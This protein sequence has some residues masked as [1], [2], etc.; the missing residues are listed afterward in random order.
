[1]LSALLGWWNGVELWLTQ[2]PF[3]MQFTLVMAVALPVSAGIA[4]LIDRAVDRVPVL[5]REVAA[6]FGA[7]RGAGPDA[8]PGS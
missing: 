4:W 8:D 3:A 5:A 6:R 1:V 7:R 2:L